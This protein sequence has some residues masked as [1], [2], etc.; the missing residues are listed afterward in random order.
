MIKE[1][2]LDID[3]LTKA[4]TKYIGK[5]VVYFQEIDSTQ[6]EAK[7]NKQKYDN[8]TIII[9]DVQ[10]AGNIAKRRLCQKSYNLIVC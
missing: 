4:N 8:G 9:A 2:L 6:L 7:R 10:N 1:K 5:K 3:K